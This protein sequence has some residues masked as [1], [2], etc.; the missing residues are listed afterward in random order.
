M[1]STVLVK[2]VDTLTLYT[3]ENGLLTCLAATASLITW[4]V[5]PNNLIFL[6]I[7]FIIEKCEQRCSGQWVK[8]IYPEVY[9]NSLLASLNTRKELR[10]MA[11]VPPRN[12]LS[13]INPADVDTTMLKSRKALEVNVQQV[14][15]TSEEQLR[16]AVPLPR[17]APTVLRW[18]PRTTVMM[19]EDV[20]TWSFCGGVLQNTISRITMTI[21]TM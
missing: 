5:M 14:V 1:P 16:E 15:V 18:Q 21:S 19:S 13:L 8:L 17:R 9:A 4:L 2:T 7:H 10:Q 20:D 3:L 12:P 6:G 11:P